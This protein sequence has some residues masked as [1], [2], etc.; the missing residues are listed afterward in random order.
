[1]NLRSLV[2]DFIGMGKDL[3]DRLRSNERKALSD[4]D[5]HLLRVHLHLLEVQS[6]NAQIANLYEGQE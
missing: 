5:L 4:V 3:S 2:R 1:M 6:A